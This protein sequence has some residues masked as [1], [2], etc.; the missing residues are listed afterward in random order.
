MCW[1]ISL[2]AQG[3]A[4]PVCS[5]SNIGGG[6]PLPCFRLTADRKP[7]K[8]SMKKRRENDNEADSYEEQERYYRIYNFHQ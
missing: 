8:M 6:K 7:C 5:K 2:L 3:L 4:S 1:T